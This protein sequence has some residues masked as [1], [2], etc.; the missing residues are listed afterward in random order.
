MFDLDFGG[1]IIDTPGIKTLAFNHFEVMD[2]AHNFR[3]IF[4]ISE[5]C[6]YADCTHRNEP[7]CAVKIAVENGDISEHRYN[8]YITLTLE[9]ED[10]NYWERHDD[11]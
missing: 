6:K 4:E 9:V 3:E 1:A 11:I 5:Q 10:Q 8:N 2:V 7:K